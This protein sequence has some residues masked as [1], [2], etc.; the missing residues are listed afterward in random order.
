M[1]VKIKDY[2]SLGQLKISEP[3]IVKKGWGHEVIIHNDEDYCG[4]VLHFNKGAEFSMH[5]HG[6]KKETWYIASGSITLKTIDTINATEEE[7]KLFAGSVIYVPRY[8]PHK[9]IVIEECDIFE[10]ST[11]HFDSDSYRIQKG[12]SQNKKTENED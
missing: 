6:I 3:E 2:K 4:K 11:Q 5:Y 7:T 8:I 1:G 9:I 12:D 10:V